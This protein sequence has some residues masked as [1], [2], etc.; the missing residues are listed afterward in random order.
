MDCDFWRLSHQ[1]SFFYFIF[2]TE[3]PPQQA[4]MVRRILLLALPAAAM[5]F[6]PAIPCVSSHVLTRPGS[7]RPAAAPTLRM[8]VIDVGSESELD[9]AIA[10]AGH[11]HNTLVHEDGSVL[12]TIS[13]AHA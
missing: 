4:W 12:I 3:F 1:K 8:A 2:P 7:C 10:G 6:G 9:S 5:A 13:R 11:L